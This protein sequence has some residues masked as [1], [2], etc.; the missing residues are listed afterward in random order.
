MHTQ[1]HFYFTIIQLRLESTLAFLSHICV[2]ES[3]YNFWINFVDQKDPGC[4]KDQKWRKI[5][6]TLVWISTISL[7]S[8]KPLMFISHL[9]LDY[10]KVQLVVKSTNGSRFF[11]RS[12]C[13]TQWQS[14]HMYSDIYSKWYLHSSAK[15]MHMHSEYPHS[16]NHQSLSLR[17]WHQ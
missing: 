5:H 2:V 8:S 1:K 12:L 6:I 9:S 15:R 11:I 7:Y 13:L 17:G 14:V 10:H 3:T 16:W 4:W